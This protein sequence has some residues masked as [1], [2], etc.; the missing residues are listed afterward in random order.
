MKLT[1]QRFAI[2]VQAPAG[3][4]GE[5]ELSG[6]AKLTVDSPNAPRCQHKGRRSFRRY[7]RECGSVR[8]KDRRECFKLSLG[9]GV[10]AVAGNSAS[11]AASVTALDPAVKCAKVTV[12]AAAAKTADASVV[13]ASVLAAAVGAVIVLKNRKH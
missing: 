4:N 11:A 5:F 8:R 2:G 7:R 10:K 12:P 3:M 6:N 13:I 1:Q 9:S